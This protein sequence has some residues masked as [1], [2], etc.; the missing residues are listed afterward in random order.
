M[1][2]SADALSR[3]LGALSSGSTD[4]RAG[5]ARSMAGGGIF[6]GEG[7]DGGG[8]DYYGYDGGGG[9]GGGRG[10]GGID[11]SGPSDYTP[12]YSWNS[13]NPTGPDNYNPSIEPPQLPS[14]TDPYVDQPMG[15]FY[16]WGGF[17]AGT[18]EFYPTSPY[19]WDYQQSGQDDV[20]PNFAAML[21]MGQ[22][23]K[24]HAQGGVIKR[25]YQDGGVT[26][27]KP[28]PKPTPRPTPHQFDPLP[29]PIDRGPGHPNFFD[30]RY[31]RSQYELMAADGGVLPD[32]SHPEWTADQSSA[33][34]PENPMQMR[35]GGMV[36]GYQDGG[37]SDDESDR[38]M[39]REGADQQMQHVQLPPQIQRILHH[40]LMQA[41]ARPIY[42]GDMLTNPP[43]KLSGY[44]GELGDG[45]PQPT[46][47][48]PQYD[49][50]G[51]AEGGGEGYA[52]GGVVYPPN[53]QAPDQQAS[54]VA[55]EPTQKEKKQPQPMGPYQFGP[56][57]FFY[58][59]EM[60]KRM[61]EAQTAAIQNEQGGAQPAPSMQPAPPQQGRPARQ[62]YAEGGVIPWHFM[63]YLA[64]GGVVKKFTPDHHL[65]FSLGMKYALSP[66][67]VAKRMGSTAQ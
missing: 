60:F 61:I 45:S 54:N 50:E 53:T 52:Q 33:R 42:T 25:G 12:P 1:A 3:L 18:P 40:H 22:V 56:A 29:V 4:D 8:G 38:R 65:M 34:S 6:R 2:I 59:P 63:Q 67:Q 66:D 47:P 17:D 9:G 46:R 64:E 39:G 44:A 57:D 37:I 10:R 48:R 49:D 13:G 28:K 11:N 19:A 35:R 62:G 51:N 58:T 43:S 24:P 27:S 5:G 55:G 20:N 30:P 31:S 26:D 21:H 7:G 23:T 16:D 14:Q 32:R 41:L 36:K 15:N